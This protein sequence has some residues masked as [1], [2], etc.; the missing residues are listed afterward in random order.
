M[1][2]E[3]Q[4]IGPA[5]FHEEAGTVIFDK[6]KSEEEIAR[7]R[8]ENEQHEFARSQVKTNKRL[9]WFTGA[10]VLASFCTIAVGIWQASI[11]GSQ[12]TAM[13]GQ[14]DQMSKQSAEIQKQTTLMR[15]QLIG[16]QAAIITL[17]PLSWNGEQSM[18]LWGT[19]ITNSGSVR[20]TVSLAANIQRRSPFSNQ[21]IGEPV[22]V[23]V[24]NEE[25]K[26]KGSY[27]LER[28]LPWLLPEVNY[29]TGVRVVAGRVNFPREWPGSEIVTV[30][31]SYSYD[32]GFHDL[33]THKFCYLWLPN[34]NISMPDGNGYAG[35]GGWSR[36]NGECPTIQEKAD[37]FR[38]ALRDAKRVLDSKKPSN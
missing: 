27:R 6:P 15:Q 32:N 26:A 31:G 11:Y 2:D 18:Q 9:A 10:L 14:L 20:G 4:G 1:S 23:N 29:A 35:G 8:R 5:P 30:E 28:V 3:E 21:A 17:E 16:T 38:I 13:Q 19:D 36:G 24:S 22:Q 12:L 37:E 34:W 25:V 7:Q 33:I